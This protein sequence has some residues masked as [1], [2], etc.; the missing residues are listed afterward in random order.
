MSK[1]FSSVWNFFER[2]AKIVI[3]SILGFFKI[4]LSEEKW[5]AFMQFV[6]FCIV[7]VSNTLISLGVY[8]IC[9]YLIFGGLSWHDQIKVQLSNIIAF[10]ISVTN[11][12]YWNSK[13]VFSCGIRR[14]FKMHVCAYLKA[15]FSYSLTGL[16][17]SAALL[18]LWTDVCG[19][20][21]GV[22]PVI[23]LLITIPLNFILNKF[24]AFANNKVKT[25]EQSADVPCGENAESGVQ[26][27][28]ATP[29]DKPRDTE[30][31]E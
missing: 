4:K 29:E 2:I 24:W 7:G 5:A 3:F 26:D 20:N 28:D 27:P 16:F 11:A 15:F 31:G 25:P 13:Y 10:V 30:N 21:S 18:W 19:V 17:L 12:Y 23:N 9:Y 1:L 8:W 22:A 6:K 14:T